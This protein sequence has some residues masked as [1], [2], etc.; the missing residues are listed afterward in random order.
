[1]LKVP[2]ASTPTQP[3]GPPPASAVDYLMAAAELHQTGAL[4]ALLAPPQ[5][6]APR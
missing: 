3:S 2:A 4:K 5:P 6:K 1:M